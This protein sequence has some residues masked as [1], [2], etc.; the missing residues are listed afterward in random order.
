[1]MLSA[2]LMDVLMC[3]RGQ[4]Q[5]P[6]PHLLT[7][8][9]KFSS[10]PSRNLSVSQSSNNLAALLHRNPNP[11]DLSQRSKTPGLSSKDNQLKLTPG[12]SSSKPHSPDL[13]LDSQH[14]IIFSSPSLP[15][16][17]ASRQPANLL[18]G[19]RVP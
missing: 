14:R 17:Q 7:Q 8:D 19:V 12:H 9:H 4:A 11:K 5:D 2:A 15:P 10:N 6:P 3:A 18:F 1:M 13:W 16:D